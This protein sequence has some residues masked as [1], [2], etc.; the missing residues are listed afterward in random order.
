MV[1]LVDE[2]VELGLQFGQGVGV[3]LAGEPAFEGLV[4]AFD[5][6]AGGGVVGGG[7]D[8]DDAKVVQFVLQGV[9]AASAAGQSGGEHHAVVGQC[10]VRGAVS[11]SGFAEFVGDDGAG[12]A[13]VRGHGDGVA[14]VVV[15]PVE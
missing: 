6:A 10:R 7:V 11:G 15:E 2:G 5:F 3:G 1:V 9:A 8:L 14:G 4:E 13:G 12:D